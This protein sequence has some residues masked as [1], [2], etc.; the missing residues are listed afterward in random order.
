MKRFSIFSAASIK[1]P[2]VQGQAGRLVWERQEIFFARTLKQWQ[3]A[4]VTVLAFAAILVGALLYEAGL[5]KQVPYVVE[6]DHGQP[7]MISPLSWRSRETPAI[8]Q[9]VVNNWIENARTVLMEPAAQKALLERVYAYAANQTVAFLTAYYKT[10]NPYVRA[11]KE[12]I[13][14]H[15][16]SSMPL[17][18]HTWQVVW[19]ERAVQPDSG[20]LLNVHRYTATLTY[21][22]SALNPHFLNQ[23]PFGLYITGVNWVESEGVGQ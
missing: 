3:W 2:Y 15:I 5:P 22:F 21:A 19:D 6:V 14:V 18:K 23:N 10:Q 16:I 7:L 9:W 8:I 1:N 13:T 12:Q 20:L 11:Q 17:G 4:F